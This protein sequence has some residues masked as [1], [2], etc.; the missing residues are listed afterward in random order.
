LLIVG[1]VLLVLILIDLS[2][3][4]GNI[5]FYSKW[6][7]CGQ[8][9]LITQSWAGVAWYEQDVVFQPILRGDKWF[10]TPLEAERAGYSANKDEYDFPHLRAAGEAPTY[11]N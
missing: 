9:P 3:L 5:R 7:E 4:G 8:R 1:A 6:I 11:E 2:P 10:C